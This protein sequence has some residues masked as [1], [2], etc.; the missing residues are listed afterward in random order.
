MIITYYDGSTLECDSIEIYGDTIIASG[1]YSIP[2]IEINR[3]DP[4]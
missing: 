3:I 1:I 4:A 2:I